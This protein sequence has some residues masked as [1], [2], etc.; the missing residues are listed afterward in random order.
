MSVAN[1][2]ICQYAPKVKYILMAK[3]GMAFKAMVNNMAN[4]HTEKLQKQIKKG[5]VKILKP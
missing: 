4:G 3:K 5:T 1:Q 2:D